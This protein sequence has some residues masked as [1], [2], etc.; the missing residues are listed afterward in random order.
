MR[1]IGI[2]PAR[3]GSTRLPGKP[4]ID[5][6]GRPMIW[7]VYN[8]TRNTRK[9]DEIYVATDDTR[10]ELECMKYHIPVVMTSGSHPT[11]AQRLYEV[12]RTIDADLYIQINGDEPL[13]D[14]NAITAAIPSELCTEREFGT[15]IITNISNTVELMDPSNIKVVFGED[16][17][18]RYMSRT[19]IPYPY[20][21]IK[22]DYYKHVGIIGYNKKMLEFYANSKPGRFETIEGID[23]LRFIDYG[24]QLKL[25]YV[26]QC[27][28][29]SVDTEKDLEIVRERMKTEKWDTE[30]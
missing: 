30:I 12:S 22:F 19:P 23:T 29:F 1:I 20:K 15:N 11:A 17:N 27:L 24:K 10:I 6:C 8:R 5:I 13:I 4:L 14:T 7:W 21:S 16:M 18:A 9:I 28:S 2:I 25:I 26:P 3:Y